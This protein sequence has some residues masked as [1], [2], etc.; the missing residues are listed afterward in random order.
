MAD[1]TYAALHASVY[2]GNLLNVAV[3]REIADLNRLFL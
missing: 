3:R 1:R 2:Q